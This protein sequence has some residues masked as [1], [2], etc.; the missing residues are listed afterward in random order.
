MN[1][2]RL[3]P[4]GLVLSLALSLFSGCTAL[5]RSAAE[6][7]YR[8]ALRDGRISP[9]DYMQQREEIRRVSEPSR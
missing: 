7:P 3:I 5:A 6:K 4:L 9:S 1:M 2:K 8:D